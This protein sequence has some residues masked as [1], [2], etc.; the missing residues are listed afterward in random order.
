MGPSCPVLIFQFWVRMGWAPPEGPNKVLTM[1][2][3][4]KVKKVT[5]VFEGNQLKTRETFRSRNVG[6]G[7]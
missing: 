5:R 6:P 4:N 7:F 3:K 1:C 2:Q